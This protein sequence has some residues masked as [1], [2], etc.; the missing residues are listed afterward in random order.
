MTPPG[1][2]LEILTAPPFLVRARGVPELESAIKD[3]LKQWPQAGRPAGPSVRY[4]TLMHGGRDYGFAWRR[5]GMTIHLLAVYQLPEEKAL[6]EVRLK[7]L[8]KLFA[9]AEREAK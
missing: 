9:S 1:R 6:F 4:E 3:W 8:V 5:K 2:Y 7:E